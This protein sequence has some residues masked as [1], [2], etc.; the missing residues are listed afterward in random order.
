MTKPPDFFIFSRSLPL[1]CFLAAPWSPSHLLVS[2]LVWLLVHVV[3]LRGSFGPLLPLFRRCFW[4]FFGQFSVLSH[5]R[6]VPR[7]ASFVGF[8]CP[9]SSCNGDLASSM[10]LRVWVILFLSVLVLRTCAA[11]VLCLLACRGL[12]CGWRCSVLLHQCLNCTCQVS[13][14][15]LLYFVPLFPIAI[16]GLFLLFARSHLRVWLAR[17]S[18]VGLIRAPTVLIFSVIYATP[19]SAGQSTFTLCWLEFVLLACCRTL[20]RLWFSSFLTSFPCN[21]S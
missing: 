21:S 3:G 5:C 6:Y 7:S 17:F 8:Q 16:V 14:P 11:F 19:W 10:V 2:L 4:T 15:S 1:R 12:S 9:I 18:F 20:C 13:S